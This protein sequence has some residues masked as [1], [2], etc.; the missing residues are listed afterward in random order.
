MKHLFIYSSFRSSGG[1]TRKTYSVSW[2]TPSQQAPQYLHGGVTLFLEKAQLLDSGEY[3]CTVFD[4]N[5]PRRY[6]EKGFQVTVY[7]EFSKKQIH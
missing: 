2:K 5:I 7:C 1:S 3:T 6:D 4:D